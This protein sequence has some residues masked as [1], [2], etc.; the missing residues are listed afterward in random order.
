V[1]LV[2]QDLSMQ[3]NFAHACRCTLSIVIY[4]T[5]LIILWYQAKLSFLVFTQIIW[6]DRNFSSH[7]STPSADLPSG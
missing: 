6:W 4:N 5:S 3:D 2:L 7:C 1:Q